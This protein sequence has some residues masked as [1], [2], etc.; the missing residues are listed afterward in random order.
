VYSDQTSA[1]LDT[2]TDDINLGTIFA[3]V[4]TDAL[5]VGSAALFRGLSVRLLDAVS[6]TAAVLTVSYWADGWVPL[7]TVDGTAKTSGKAFSGGGAV[8]WKVPSAWVKR[9][10]N[11]S[12]AL[13]FVKVTISAT[14]TGAKASQLG[15]IRR[16]ALAAPATFRTLELIMREAP[17]GGG[18]PWTEKA[19]YYKGEADLALQRA[20]A[21]VG[22]EFETD[23]PETDL[24]DPDE[25]DQTVEEAGGGWRME[26]A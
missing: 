24:I 10:V 7:V 6:S 1:G 14:P 11:G 15:V 19:D 25:A 4:G 23:D 20:L 18:G 21:I 22:G 3:T 26:R 13:Y 16:S 5:Y 12:S 2:N 17:T 9:T 8:T